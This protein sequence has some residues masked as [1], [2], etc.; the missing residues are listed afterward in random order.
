MRSTM[1]HAIGA[2]HAARRAKKR[3]EA[4]TKLRAQEKELGREQRETE[5]RDRPHRDHTKRG[6]RA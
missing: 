2:M 1:I 5:G 6:Q 3:L 4:E